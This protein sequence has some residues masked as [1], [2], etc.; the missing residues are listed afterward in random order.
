MRSFCTHTSQVLKLRYTSPFG[1]RPVIN[2][3]AGLL[4]TKFSRQC[5]G[6]GN[7]V[8]YKTFFHSL[9]TCGE[10]S[11]AIAPRVCTR[12][13]T[14]SRGGYHGDARGHRE[15]LTYVSATSRRPVVPPRRSRGLDS[16]QRYSDPYGPRV[17]DHNPHKGPVYRTPGLPDPR[18]SSHFPQN[19][20]NHYMGQSPFRGYIGDKNQ[21]LKPSCSRYAARAATSRIGTSN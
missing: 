9:Y 5:L 12:D 17:S 1:F 2:V 13:T 8:C 16:H 4:L 3:Y 15:A 7:E 14:A 21:P 6:Q 19:A 11:T 10:C 20:R 18:L